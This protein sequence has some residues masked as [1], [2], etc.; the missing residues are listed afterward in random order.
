M[1]LTFDRKLCLDTLKAHTSLKCLLGVFF[2]GGF[3]FM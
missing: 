2:F 1:Q 3:D